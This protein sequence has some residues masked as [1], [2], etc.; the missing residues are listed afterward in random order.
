[1]LNSKIMV[2]MTY[3]CNY[4]CSYCCGCIDF[5][6]GNMKLNYSYSFI[7]TN[8]LLTFLINNNFDNIYL[9]GGEPTLHP[10]LKKVCNILIKN[11]KNVFV[12][13]NLSQTI[14]YYNELCN[15]GVKLIA[16]YHITNILFFEKIRNIQTNIQYIFIIYTFN[17]MQTEY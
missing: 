5:Y 14:D 12:I 1:M 6:N 8:K 3:L 4:K 16:S 10:Q 13:T 17:Y 9:T 15:I 2:Y 7:N 11:N